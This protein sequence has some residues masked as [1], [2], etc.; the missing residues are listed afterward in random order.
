MRFR[1]FN[2]VFIV[3]LLLSASYLSLFGL[4]IENGFSNT[5]AAPIFP[6]GDGSAGNPYQ[7]SNVTELQ[8]MSANLSAHYVLIND[9]DASNTSSWNGGLGFSPIGNDTNNV[10]S[11]FQG[12]KFTG[13][14]EGNGY[15]IINLTI[16]RSG[17][18]YV[19]L[20]G[21]TDTGSQINNVSVIN[22]NITGD[23]YVGILAGW[24]NATMFNIHS[25]GNVTGFHTVGGLIGKMP[26]GTLENSSSYGKVRGA[27]WTGGLIGVC[28]SSINYCHSGC[29]VLGSVGIAFNTGGFIGYLSGVVNNSYAT[30]DVYGHDEVGGFVGGLWG[31]VLN[32]WSKGDVNSTYRYGGGLVGW[33]HTGS[34]MSRCYSTG[35]VSITNDG[36]GGLVGYMYKSQVES[37]YSLGD[38]TGARRV[39][40]LVGWCRSSPCLI[41]NSYSLSTVRGNQWVGGL[42]GYHNFA[43]IN[44][45]YSAGFVNGT[46][47]AGGLVGF[48][49]VGFVFNSF[50]DNITSN[51]TTSAGGMGN[52]TSELV[53]TKTFSDVGWDFNN[54]WTITEGITYPYFPWQTNKDPAILGSDKTTAT[55][56]IFYE[57][58][59]DFRDIEYPLVF[60]LWSLFTNASWLSIDPVTGKLSG[61]P[62]N[63]DVGSYWINVTVDDGNGGTHSK[64]FSLIVQNVNDDPIITTTLIPEAANEDSLYFIDFE[65][66]DIDPTGDTFTWDFTSNATWLMIDSATGNLT[67]TP[68]DPDIGSFWVN[69]TVSDGNGGFDTINFTINVTNINDIPIIITTDLTTATEDLLYSVDYEATDADPTDDILTWSLIGAESWLNINSG[70]GILSGTPENA[71]VGNY[72][73][74]VSVSDGKGGVTWHYFPIAVINVNDPPEIT[75]ENVTSTNEDELYI[76]QYDAIDIDPTG[77]TLT[78]MLNTDANWLALD[79]S[80]NLTGTPLNA[81]VGSYWVNVTVSDDNDGSAWQNF[82][83]EVINVNDPPLITT[84]DVVTAEVDVLYSVDYHA[85]DMDPTDDIL[86]WSLDTNAT[87]LTISPSTGVLSGTPTSNDAGTYWVN[88]SVSDYY[89]GLDWNNFEITVPLIV[90]PVNKN[91]VITTDNVLTAEVDKLY[92]VD[93]DAT[94]DHTQ[95]INLTWS[96]TTNASWLTIDTSMGVLSGTPGSGDVGTFNVNVSVSDG[97]GGLAFT[98]FVVA[99]NKPVTPPENNKPKLSNG[100]MSPSEGDSETEFTFSVHYADSDDDAPETIQVVIDGKPYAMKLVSGDAGD[101]VYEYKTKLVEGDHSYYFTASDGTDTAEP[102]DTTPTTSDTAKTTPEIE[103]KAAADDTMMYIAILIVIIIIIL[104]LGLAMRRKK[105]EEPAEEET[106]EGEETEEDEEE[107]DEIEAESFNCPECSEAIREDMTECDSCGATLEWGEEEIP[108]SELDEEDLDD[109]ELPE[110]S[111]PEAEAEPDEDVDEEAEGEE[112]EEKA[113]AG[114]F[115]CPDCGA[116]L[117]ADITSCPDCGAD[118]ED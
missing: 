3:I 117:G 16:N 114:E 46:I 24:S 18:D 72:W 59:Y 21:Y 76:V 107:T 32:S 54:N 77:D 118:F 80:N 86:T 39:G 98:N 42:V 91:P 104:L 25:Q 97:E 41:E 61:T 90:I 112:S 57:V 26:V 43:V 27:S 109:E 1:L 40:G 81:D 23:L 55:E 38:V 63:T 110:D 8:N 85:T 78:W 44:N 106:Q 93:Y 48:N 83:L 47:S 50:F 45:S 65:A 35:D 20:I 36:S 99:V 71:D 22:S 52:N 12:T 116:T 103:K 10:T 2:S 37:C 7:I 5:S 82:T 69:V 60:P 95:L 75:T 113:D 73:V 58:D 101:G 51:Q 89:G 88:V 4:F 64:N 53:L 94:D 108:D 9:I 96:V 105:K 115:E 49:S 87:W 15:K 6:G 102:G 92:S 56:D 74:N 13:S 70:T 11:D 19:G 111:E 100:K 66:M 34:K 17:E 79:S 84:E 28:Y 29:E 67:G 30:G 14:F 62:E 68:D 31:T 33:A